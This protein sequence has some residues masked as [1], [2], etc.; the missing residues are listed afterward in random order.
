MF[1]YSRE[2]GSRAAKMEGQIPAA[3]KRRRHAKAMKLQQRIAVE[4]SR[5]AV[6]RTLRVL[7]DAPLV[8]RTQG[9]APEVDGRVLLR[10]ARAGR[11]VH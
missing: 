2:E 10:P 7:T 3:V 11:R 5:R 4:V 1:S 8:A 6:G 9:D